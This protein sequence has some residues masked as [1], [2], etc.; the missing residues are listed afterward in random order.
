MKIAIIGAGNVGKGQ[1]SDLALVVARRD[2]ANRNAD[3]RIR[4]VHSHP[5]EAE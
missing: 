2:A 1:G 5:Q 3:P 4:V